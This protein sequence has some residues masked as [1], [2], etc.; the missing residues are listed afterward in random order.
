L[1]LFLEALGLPVELA[2]Y[3]AGVIEIEEQGLVE[4]F[5]AHPAIETLNEAV[6][7]G[8]FPAR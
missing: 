5:I 7:R 4:Q 8:L 3:G 6:P 1:N 2:I